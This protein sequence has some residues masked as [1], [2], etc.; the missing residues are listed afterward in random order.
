[1]SAKFGIWWVSFS[2][3][4]Q[5]IIFMSLVDGHVPR[6]VLLFIALFFFGLGCFFARL[7]HIQKP[8]V[9]TLYLCILLG[10]FMSGFAV[11]GALLVETT[12]SENLGWHNLV[13]LWPFAVYAGVL[14]P[15]AMYIY[16]KYRLYVPKAT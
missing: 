9:S 5:L 1:M 13:V 15:L 10:A 7:C 6:E 14:I 11:L 3:F 4:V 2:M 8:V 16:P 12:I